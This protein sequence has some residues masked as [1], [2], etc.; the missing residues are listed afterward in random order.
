MFIILDNIWLI[1]GSICI[2]AALAI[3]YSCLDDNGKIK[4]EI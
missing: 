1:T 2:I 4:G 3:N